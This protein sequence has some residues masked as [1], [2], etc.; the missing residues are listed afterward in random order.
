MYAHPA[1]KK[2][3]E[4]CFK[5]WGLS[6]NYGGP[7]GYQH[8]VSY[9]LHING[10]D[11]SES[12]KIRLIEIVGRTVNQYLTDEERRVVRVHYVPAPDVRYNGEFRRC[13]VSFTIRQL[14]KA[15]IKRVYHQKINRVLDEAVSKLARVLSYPSMLAADD[16]LT[17]DEKKVCNF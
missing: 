12:S 14:K 2:Y 1:D 3:A 17:E 9:E 10:Q 4:D 7:R 5:L 8:E 13:V 6:L 11:V 16:S 15:G